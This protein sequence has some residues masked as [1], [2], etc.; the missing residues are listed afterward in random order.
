[1]DAGKAGGDVG[2]DLHPVATPNDNTTTED[3]S[4]C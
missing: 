2:F 3:K 1:V 4:C